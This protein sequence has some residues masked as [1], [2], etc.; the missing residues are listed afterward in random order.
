MG[1]DRIDSSILR[2]RSAYNAAADRM[3]KRVGVVSM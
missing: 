3:I 2:D 1:K